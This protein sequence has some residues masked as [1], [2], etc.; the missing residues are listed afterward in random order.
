[1]VRKLDALTCKNWQISQEG[2]EGFPKYTD[3]VTFLERRVQSYE[4]VQHATDFSTSRMPSNKSVKP[5]T[6]VNANKAKSTT[7]FTVSTSDSS[8]S[9][10]GCVLCKGQ[11][12]LN[13]CE[14][15]KLMTTPQR[16]DFCKQSK[17]CLNCL[18]KSHFSHVCPSK[19]RCF[20][21]KGKHHTKL[22]EDRKPP[23]THP[24]QESP[25]PNGDH[26]AANFVSTKRSTLLATA[27]IL[28]IDVANSSIPARALIDPGAERSFITTRLA[29]ILNSSKRKTPV[30]ISGVGAKS[31]AITSH[32]VT[33]SLGSPVDM[34]FS[35]S[36]S[37]LVLPKLTGL[38]PSQ[39]LEAQEWPHLKGI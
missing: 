4:Q 25:P 34:T 18:A 16:L 9:T 32:E 17:L 14:Q 36:C 15:F 7:A 28:I 6:S 13:S 22:H 38:L 10:P 23:I 35:L 20:Q 37:A 11:H 24:P 21:C 29:S 39:D 8:K 27:R 1:M 5:Q 19:Y 33:L 12:S 2:K 31:V 30:M 3:L 26:C